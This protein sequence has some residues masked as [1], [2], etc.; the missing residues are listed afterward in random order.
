MEFGIDIPAGKPFDAVG[1]GL[2]AV[3]HLILVPHYPEFNTKIKFVTHR[4]T[5]GGQ[6]AT[7]MAAL[8]RL[9]LRTRYIGNV[10]S[11]RLGRFQLESLHQD[12]I[13]SS[14]VRVVDGAETQ[15]AFIIV[16]Q[17]SGERTVIWSRDPR[18]EIDTATIDEQAVTSGRVLHLDG[19][20]VQASIAAAKFARA[21]GIPTCLD[22]D[23]IYPDADRLLPLIDFMISSSTF[24][25]RM[26]GAPD[27]ESA[28]R[29]LHDEF[30]SSFVAATLGDRGVVAYYGG[31]YI[32]SPAFKVDCRDTTGAGDAFHGGFLYG[33]LAGYS[34]EAT[35]RFANAVAGLKCRDLGARTALPSPGD[36]RELL[37]LCP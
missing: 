31:E 22:I 16:D 29:K 24:P 33:V 4:L 5:P 34:V 19:H 6:A 7:A 35:L 9:G 32:Y 13:E 23:N 25:E 1:L 27:L 28:L 17:V 30:G 37:D 2:N 18:L 26:T 15:T 36:V 11:D 10:G 3:D 12:G 21:A 20:D 8:A 14:E